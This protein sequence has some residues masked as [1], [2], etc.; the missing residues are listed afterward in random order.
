MFCHIY[1]VEFLRAYNKTQLPQ[2]LK[3]VDAT[4]GPEAAYMVDHNARIEYM[5]RHKI[6]IEVLTL[7]FQNA[8]DTL[9]EKDLMKITKIANDSI[10]NVASRHPERMVGIA[11]LPKLTEE[12]LDELDRSI[13]DLGMRGCV[14]FTNI[15]G[16]P[17]DSP[18]FLHFFERMA[19]YDLPI[20]LHP[21]NWAYYPWVREYRLGQIFGWPFDT[22]LAMARIVFGGIFQRFPNLKIVTHHLGGMIPFYGERVREFYDETMDQPEIYGAGLFPYSEMMQKAAS[23]PLDDFK[24]FYGDT[25]VYG[26]MPSLKCGLDFFGSDH[27]VFATDYPFGTNKGERLTGEIIDSLMKLDVDEKERQN[28]FE[29]NAR[30]ILKLA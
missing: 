23:H 9:T 16:K 14:I 2:L 24:K 29:S 5:D 3:F 6:D 11:M 27:V 15:L 30:R 28:I 21:T 26:N 18:E 7:A 8:I 13:K 19:K 12:Y 4:A 22:S 10:A 25:V 20:L 1:P 17:V